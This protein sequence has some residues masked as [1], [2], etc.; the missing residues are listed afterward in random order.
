MDV[1]R[2]TDIV[3][4]GGA[5]LSIVLTGQ[6]KLR[7]N[8]RRASAKATRS[9]TNVFALDG[10]AGNEREFLAWLL[11]D[12]SGGTIEPHAVLT[13]EAVDMLTSKLRMQW[14]LTQAPEAGYRAGV[15]P[16][17]VDLPATAFL[18]PL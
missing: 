12:C 15:S 17:P 6:Q 4:E 5:T 9:R 18:T 1:Q 14:H 7:E 3:E 13:E 11:S 10:I 16:V 2:L 8:V